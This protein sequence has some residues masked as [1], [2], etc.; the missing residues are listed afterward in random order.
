MLGTLSPSVAA[1]FARSLRESGAH[2]TLV[3]LL[4]STATGSDTTVPTIAAAGPDARSVSV[5]PSIAGRRNSGNCAGVFSAGVAANAVNYTHQK[6]AE[7]SSADV[8]ANV[9]N[10]THQMWA[11]TSSACVEVHGPDGLG[12]RERERR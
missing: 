9:L 4:P 10:Y 6:L 11:E 1:R 7:M 2:C 8:A 12:R 5:A 3:I